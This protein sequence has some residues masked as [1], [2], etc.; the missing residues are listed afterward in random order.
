MKA[1]FSTLG[2]KLKGTGIS[3]SQFLALAN[4]TAFGP[5][6]QSELADHLAIT[7]ATTARLVDRMERD[8]WVRR[9]RDPNDQRIKMVISTEKAAGIWEEISQSG[10]EVLEQAYQGVTPEELDTVKRIL[11]HIRENLNG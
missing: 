1:F 9:E 8:E 6:S 2:D 10:R 11:K 5:L 4:L 3:P 7:G